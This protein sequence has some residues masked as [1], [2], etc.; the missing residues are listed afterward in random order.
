MAICSFGQTT[1]FKK[2]LFQAWEKD[3]SGSYFIHKVSLS[4]SGIYFEVFTN[5]SYGSH[6]HFSIF[7]RVELP[8]A[9][10]SAPLA[11]DLASIARPAK[12][13]A[14]YLHQGELL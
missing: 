3:K 7:F 10:P 4:Y 8:I 5:L 12:D 6:K 11:R 9:I 14:Q 2:P 1:A 13:R